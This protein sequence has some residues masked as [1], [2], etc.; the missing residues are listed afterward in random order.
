M[1]KKKKKKKFDKCKK[2]CCRWISGRTCPTR[3]KKTHPHWSYSFGE[4]S[5]H[6]KETNV[7]LR[8]LPFLQ[9]WY[10]NIF[11]IKLFNLRLSTDFMLND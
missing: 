2:E 6:K 5:I 3:C 1:Q 11:Q 10:K 8:Y 9:S 7:E 4:I